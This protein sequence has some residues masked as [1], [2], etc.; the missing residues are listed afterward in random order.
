[1]TE[2]QEDPESYRRRFEAFMEVLR[3]RAWLLALGSTAIGVAIVTPVL[4]HPQLEG[5]VI[6]AVPTFAIM[7][8]MFRTAPRWGP[9]MMGY[10]D[11]ANEKYKWRPDSSRRSEG[12][13]HRDRS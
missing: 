3:R 6:A 10:D 4:E 11:A 1:M 9:Q 13:D 8:V 5:V 12:E 7:F 2:Q